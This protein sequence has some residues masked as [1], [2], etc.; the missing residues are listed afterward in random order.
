MHFFLL[1]FGLWQNECLCFLR[2]SDKLFLESGKWVSK[3]SRRA[4]QSA[5]V[6]IRSL[7]LIVKFGWSAGISPKEHWQEDIAIF[8]SNFITTNTILGYL[9]HRDVRCCGKINLRNRIGFVAH[10]SCLVS[11]FA[12]SAR[13]VGELFYFCGNSFLISSRKISVWDQGTRD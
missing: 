11:F 2:L 7:V 10:L 4:R 12:L 13:W 3:G 1:S 9:K 6:R 8:N 5:P